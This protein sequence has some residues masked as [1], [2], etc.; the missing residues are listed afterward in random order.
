[1][2]RLCAIQERSFHLENGSENSQG[3]IIDKKQNQEGYM[4]Y[5]LLLLTIDPAARPVGR[6][7]TV[8]V[9]N[10]GKFEKAA[11]VFDSITNFVCE[12]L[13]NATNACQA[14]LNQSSKEQTTKT[15]NPSI[16][17]DYHLIAVD[18]VDRGLLGPPTGD[19]ARSAK[20]G[21]NSGKVSQE[22]AW[23]PSTSTRVYGPGITRSHARRINA[24]GTRVGARRLRGS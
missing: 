17:L 5:R 7:S 13:P 10:G 1:M 21:S 22:E 24:P 23:V 18:A 20:S 8:Q 6:Y 19:Q 11:V 12:I 15:R 3:P 16:K 9:S 2:R 4:M 14:S